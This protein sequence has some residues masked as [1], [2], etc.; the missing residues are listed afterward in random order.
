MHAGGGL[1][2]RRLLLLLRLLG[3]HVAGDEVLL[4]LRRGGADQRAQGADE[5]VGTRCRLAAD[6]LLQLGGAAEH[7]LAVRA[8]QGG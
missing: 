4:Q 7:D 1:L 2:A 8:L 6:V 3:F 5:P